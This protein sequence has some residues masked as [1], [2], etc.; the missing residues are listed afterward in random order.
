MV[1][2]HSINSCLT[3]LGSD[4]ILQQL[5]AFILCLLH[6]IHAHNCLGFSDI[7][8]QICNLCS[9]QGTEFLDF[10]LIGRVLWAIE[11]AGLSVPPKLLEALL[12]QAN[13]DLH[14]AKP[15]SLCQFLGA[16]I[17]LGLTSNSRKPLLLGCIQRGS[18]FSL[19]L[20]KSPVKT[21]LL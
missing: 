19:S 12:M 2:S 17:K 5:A 11:S 1:A 14:T 3:V 10:S 21:C 7:N 9:L 4:C 20:M 6:S 13:A 16:S 8:R 18:C 15:T